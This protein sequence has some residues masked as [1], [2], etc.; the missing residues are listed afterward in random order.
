M[1]KL[2]NDLFEHTWKKHARIMEKMMKKSRDG[3]VHAPMHLLG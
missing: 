3:F 1:L 2:S